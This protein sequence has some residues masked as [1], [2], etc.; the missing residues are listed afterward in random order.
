MDWLAMILQFAFFMPITWRVLTRE[1]P[2]TTVFHELALMFRTPSLLL[3]LIGLLLAWFGWAFSFW[4]GGVDPRATPRSVA[5]IGFLLV[6]TLLMVWSFRVF[7]SWRLLPQIAADHELCTAGPYR[8]IRHP[9]YLAFDLQ[10]IGIALSAP[11]PAVIAGAFLLIVAGDRRA[12]NEEH[13][14]ARAFG[15]R[16]RRYIGQVSR[17]IP[18]IY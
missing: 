3:H 16:Y 15:D 8:F 13:A 17:T 6:S 7:R 18:G 10:G 1:R 11:N 14:L 4:T 2:E 12:R 9:I 5:A